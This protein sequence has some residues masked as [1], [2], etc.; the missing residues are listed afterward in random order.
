MADVTKT[1]PELKVTYRQ[2]VS[3]TLTEDNY[4]GSAQHS[5]KIS[6]KYT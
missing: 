3:G 6:W 1:L 5:R 4:A 2:L